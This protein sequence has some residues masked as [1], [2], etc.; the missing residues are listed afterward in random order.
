MEE[1]MD[2]IDKIGIC[3]VIAF[4]AFVFH[5]AYRIEHDKQITIRQALKENCT[6]ID[7]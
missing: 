1:K 7:F 2:R 3:I 4:L 5:F 6:L